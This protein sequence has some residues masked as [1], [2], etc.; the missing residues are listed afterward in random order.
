MAKQKTKSK[1]RPVRINED[2]IAAVDRALDRLNLP[3]SC[4]GGVINGILQTCADW[5]GTDGPSSATDND[6]SGD[7]EIKSTSPSRTGNA[8]D[9][10]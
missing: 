7:S 6:D 2:S 9:D 3:E 8:F 1:S 5:Y 10:F 4:R